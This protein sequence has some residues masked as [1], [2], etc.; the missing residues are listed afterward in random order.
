M[1]VVTS[2]IINEGIAQK[3][4]K[5]SNIENKA[6]ARKGMYLH[7]VKWS[8]Y[9]VFC[10]PQFPVFGLNTEILNTAFSPNTGKYG[11]EKPLYLDNFHA[12]LAILMYLP[13]GN[14]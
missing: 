11:A 7:W 8:K 13:V 6:A 5:C 2:C 3:L 4:G 1:E 9:E 14:C 12:V 10:G